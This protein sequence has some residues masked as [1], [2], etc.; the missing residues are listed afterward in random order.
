[1]RTVWPPLV[2]VLGAVPVAVARALVDAGHD[3]SAGAGYG[4]VGAVVVL[5]LTAGWV[6]TRA[7]IHAWFE[8][9]S[10]Q[11]ATGGSAAGTDDERDGGSDEDQEHDGD[12]DRRR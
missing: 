8:E 12:R 2:A 4:V 3:A 7:D 11:A 10:Q 9:V 5:A 6:R 1:M